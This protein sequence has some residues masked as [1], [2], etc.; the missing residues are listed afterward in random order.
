MSVNAFL[1]ITFELMFLEN[2]KENQIYI[3]AVG[4]ASVVVP[5]N[6]KD[7]KE[8]KPLLNAIYIFT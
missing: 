1:K 4:V 7:E 3:V 8:K 6:R 2:L 5:L